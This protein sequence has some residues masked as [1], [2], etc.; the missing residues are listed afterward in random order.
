ML[1]R[2][3]D[4]DRRRLAVYCLKDAYLPQQVKPTISIEKYYSNPPYL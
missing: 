2:G 3:S 1:Q 4:A